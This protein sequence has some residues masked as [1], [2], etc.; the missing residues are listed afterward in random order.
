MINI[1]Y[2]L[3]RSLTL[4]FWRILFNHDFIQVFLHD[5]ML[6]FTLF[7]AETLWVNKNKFQKHLEKY[8]LSCFICTGEDFGLNRATVFGGHP[9]YWK[10]SFKQYLLNLHSQTPGG[11]LIILV[12]IG[13]E[14]QSKIHFKMLMA[15]WTTVER[16]LLPFLWAFLWP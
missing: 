16:Q 12:Q 3:L 13:P 15:K 1:E 14:I 7:R 2:L 5:F 4:S 8:Q 6:W 10:K 9:G 11:G